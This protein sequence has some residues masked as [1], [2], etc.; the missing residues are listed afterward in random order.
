[1]IVGAQEKPKFPGADS[2]GLS[3]SL[4]LR[5]RREGE[6]LPLF[7]PG[8]GSGV[9]LLGSG[10][11]LNFGPTLHL[12]AARRDQD[13]GAP[14]GKVATTIE[15]GGFASAWLSPWLRVRAEVRQGIGGH[16]GLVGLLSSDAV[17]VSDDGNILSIGPRLRLA[18]GR[19]QRAYFGVTQLVAARTGLPVWRPRGGVYGA[20][21]G[22]GFLHQFS[23]RWGIAAYATYDRLVGDSSRSPIVRRFGSRDQLSAGIGL[24]YTFAIRR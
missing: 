22:T 18:D 9:G 12:Q 2:L 17:L 1:M 11:K 24:T 14:V 13:V 3:P 6:R 5:V 16:R 19:Y 10:E 20:G 7:A 23:E 15:A 4:H 8:Q 21:V